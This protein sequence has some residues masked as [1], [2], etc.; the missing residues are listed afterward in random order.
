MHIADEVFTS[1]TLMLSTEFR[2]IT[3]YKE[4]IGFI[5]LMSFLIFVFGASF[6]VKYTLH[7]TSYNIKF[8][9]HVIGGTTDPTLMTNSHRVR[10]L[11]RY[12][13]VRLVLD[14]GSQ[15]RFTQCMFRKS[16][17]R[18]I[19]QRFLYKTARAVH[20]PCVIAPL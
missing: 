2:N 6:T 4:R 17:R 18:R 11:L 9:F 10:F 3:S 7:Q 19:S 8:L 13:N 12:M 20:K 1:A 14:F 16:G 5:Y 15:K